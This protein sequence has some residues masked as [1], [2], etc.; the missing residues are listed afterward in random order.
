MNVQQYY[1]V[2]RTTQADLR[3]KF[4]QGFCLV[5]SVDSLDANSTPGTVSEVS[6]P[7]AAHWIVKGSH[8]LATEQELQAFAEGL[9]A[10]RARLRAVSL[11]EN[12]K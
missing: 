1:A 6:V 2:L 10:T 8:R 7:M 3:Q 12:R 11:E 4:P 5:T 9:E